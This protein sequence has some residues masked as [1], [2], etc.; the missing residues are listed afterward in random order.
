VLD[1]VVFQKSIAANSCGVSLVRGAQPAPPLAERKTRTAQ[2]RAHRSFTHR[3]F[4]ILDR[5]DTLLC[6]VLDGVNVNLGLVALAGDKYR[7]AAA[8]ETQTIRLSTE[9]AVQDS[10]AI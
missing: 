5:R 2:V 7:R 4:S 10:A 3:T 9:G 6:G 8:A 1:V